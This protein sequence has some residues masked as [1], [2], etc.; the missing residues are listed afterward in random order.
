MKEMIVK[1]VCEMCGLVYDR[2]KMYSRGMKFDVLGVECENGVRV[3]V[4]ENKSSFGVRVYSGKD[5]LG[6]ECMSFRIR[7]D[8]ECLVRWMNRGIGDDC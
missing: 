5:K 3:E 4:G 8:D 2:S 7:R 1:F 6:V